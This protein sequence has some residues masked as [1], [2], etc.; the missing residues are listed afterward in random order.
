MRLL[1][2]VPALIVLIPLFAALLAQICGWMNRRAVFPVAV[3]FLGADLVL[4][5]FMLFHA[6]ETGT[7]DYSMAGWPGPVGIVLRIDPFGALMVVVI[8][9]ISF[10]HLFAT[11]PVIERDMPERVPVFYS[12]YLLLVTGVLGMTVTGDAFNLYVLLEISSLTG[13]ALIGIGKNRAPLSALNY[14]FIGTVGASFYLLGTGY[15]YLLTGSLNM[16]DIAVLLPEMYDSTVLKLGFF[17][18]LVGLFLKM[19]FFPL[20]LWLPNAYSHAPG[21]VS[22]LIAPLMTKVMVFVMIRLIL[23]LFRPDFAFG[24][25]GI[26]RGIVH[27]ATIG[28]FSAAILALG[29]KNTVRVL[30]YIVIAEVGY[31]VGGFWMGNPEGMTGAMLH[32]IN[33]ALMTFCVFLGAC[34]IVYKQ[35]NAFPEALKNLFRKMP[36]TMT[37][38]VIGALSIIGVPPTCGFYSKWYLLSGAIGAGHYGFAGALLFSS[39]V[40]VV[41]FFRIFEKAFFGEDTAHGN[42]GE[43]AVSEA[44]AIMVAP[45]LISSGLLILAGL[46]AGVIVQHVIQVALSG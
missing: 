15:I 26:G 41:L 35:G 9:L 43:T 7:L 16:A 38:L 37:G 3:L 27:M 13:Y 25:L 31:M 12:L 1:S 20:H 46:Y 14:L 30:S 45:L 11:K 17:L 24:E 29:Q 28:I 32:I 34:I 4:S 42:H 39:L 2:Q 5:F 8:L 19:A 33:D 40:S 23:T 22:G 6:A 36:F 21:P 44:P 10:L 18:C